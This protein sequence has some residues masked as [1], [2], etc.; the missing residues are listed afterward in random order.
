MAV[1]RIEDYQLQELQGKQIVINKYDN[2]IMYIQEF[3]KYLKEFYF[4]VLQAMATTHGLVLRCASL[5]TQTKDYIKLVK[6]YK[7]D[8]DVRDYVEINDYLYLEDWLQID[9]NKIIYDSNG[10]YLCSK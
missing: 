5:P 10:I 1:V 4:D 2:S 8:I 3:A 6:K 7:L 9:G